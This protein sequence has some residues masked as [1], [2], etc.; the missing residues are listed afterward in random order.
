MKAIVQRAYGDASV[1]RLEETESPTIGDGEV[2]VRVRAASINHADWVYI[3]GRPSISRLAFGLRTPKTPVRGKDVAGVIEA[4][5]SGVTAFKVGDEVYGELESGTFA[6]FVAAPVAKIARK[7][8]I[9]TFEQ[10]ATIPLA[11]MT[12]YLGLRDAGAV[13]PGQRVLI[14][15]ASGGVGTFAVQ[16]AKALGAEV[17]AVASSRN[18]QLV[19]G[20][21]ADRAIDYARDD[22]TLDTARYDV[23]LDLIG[24]HS[25]GRLRSVLTPKGTLVLSSGTGHPVFGPMGRIMSAVAMSP[26]VGQTLSLFSQHGTTQ[27]LDELRELLEA[28]HVTPAIDRTF[29]LAE[30]PA[31]VE[32]F[33]DEHASGKVAISV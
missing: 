3:S 30:V 26:F 6:E 29:P 1:L 19:R 32:Y 13:T 22:F 5:G 8:A 11:G 16:I 4:V 12:A 27:V 33:V 15:G 2:L 20:L 17:T 24:N 7:P 18:A 9:L 28:G 10:A 23:I 14:N 21:G 25:L 31:A